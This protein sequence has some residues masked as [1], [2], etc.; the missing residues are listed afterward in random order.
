MEKANSLN[1]KSFAPNLVNSFL[2]F[3]IIALVAMLVLPLPVALLDTFFVL[4]ITLSLL[5]LM[6][7]LHTQRPLDFSSFPN[8]LLIATVLRLGLNVASTRIVLKDGHTG[9]DAAGKVIEAFGEFIVSGN[10]AVGIFVFTILVIINLV[11]I[12]KGAGRVSEVSARFTL[13][14][15]PGK[16]MAIDADLNAGI[17]TPEEAKERREEVSKEADFYGSMDGAS[18]FVKGDAI[19]GILIL[20]VNVVGGLIIGLLQHQLAIGQA[21][22][23][24][25]L[26]A[27]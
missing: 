11:V 8:L 20:V 6:V 19:A 26:L 24:Y 18:K 4:N 10:Y 16:Q 9:P 14:A 17:L 22:E 23:A 2:P 12:T 27:I 25:I 3:G 13:D 21:A 15:L 1:F 7:A 5:I